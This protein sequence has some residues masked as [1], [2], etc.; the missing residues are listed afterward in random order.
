MQVVAFGWR[1]ITMYVRAACRRQNLNV[2]Y[3]LCLYPSL[4]MVYVC[5]YQ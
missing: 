1:Y 5:W 3:S 4:L 2:I